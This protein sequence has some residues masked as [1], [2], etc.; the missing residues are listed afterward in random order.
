[1]VTK[2]IHKM[3]DKNGLSEI[4]SIFYYIEVFNSMKSKETQIHAIE[5]YSGAG[6]SIGVRQFKDLYLEVRDQIQEMFKEHKSEL[7]SKGE[8]DYALINSVIL[9]KFQK[10]VYS[11]ETLGRCREQLILDTKH[12]CKRQ[13]TW[14]RNRIFVDNE[15]NRKHFFVLE[16]SQK[17]NE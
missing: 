9:G 8:P 3:L 6:S 12:Y 1:M 10:I 4:F 14:I 16:L 13:I 17:Q 11:E 15:E 5:E 7:L 2:R